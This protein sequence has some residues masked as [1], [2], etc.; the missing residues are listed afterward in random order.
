M[1]CSNIIPVQAALADN[2]FYRL[3]HYV[4]GFP[5]ILN[6][7]WF[8]NLH[9]SCFYS[10]THGEQK[11]QVGSPLINLFLLGLILSFS[12][13]DNAQSQSLLMY[14]ACTSFQCLSMKPLFFFNNSFQM[15]T[16][17]IK[18]GFRVVQ[19]LA[20]ILSLLYSSLNSLTLW[21][22]WL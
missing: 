13:S 8:K 14:F 17:Q 19:L 21:R 20:Q 7:I 9:S 15:N 10:L 3:T 18:S 22:D 5:A 6:K 12:L 4:K 1:I 11:F 2:E 16:N